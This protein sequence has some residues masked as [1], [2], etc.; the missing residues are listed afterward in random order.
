MGRFVYPSAGGETYPIDDRTLAHLELVIGTKFRH[1]EAF[2]FTL[3][4]RELPA[5]SGIHMFWMSP[6]IAVEFRYDG[7]RRSIPINSVWIEKLV[8]STF[9]DVGL[10]ILPEPSPAAARQPLRG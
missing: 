10:R 1:G 6:A 4:G 7:E 2:G 9:T 8:E 5:G 3:L